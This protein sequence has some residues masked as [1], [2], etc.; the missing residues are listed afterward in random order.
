MFC[1]PI[2]KSRLPYVPT[3]LVT[4]RKMGIDRDEDRAI[5]GNFFGCFPKNSCG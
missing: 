3:L 5:R 1:A 2:K 4:Y